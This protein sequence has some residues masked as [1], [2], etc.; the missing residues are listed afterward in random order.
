M[1]CCAQTPQGHPIGLRVVGLAL[2]CRLSSQP[3]DNQEGRM[4]RLQVDMSQGTHGKR[5][6]LPGPDGEAGAEPA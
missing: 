5:H 6:G 1:G 4:D 3:S 2:Q